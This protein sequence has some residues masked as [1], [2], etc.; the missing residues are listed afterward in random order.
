MIC[1]TKTLELLF[2]STLESVIFPLSE[3]LVIYLILLFLKYSP[4]LEHESLL[5]AYDGGLK[6][7]VKSHW[8]MDL[9]MYG[10]IICIPAGHITRSD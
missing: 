4:S 6:H 5:R 8:P 10:G 1:L 7:K 9:V 2:R 3:Y